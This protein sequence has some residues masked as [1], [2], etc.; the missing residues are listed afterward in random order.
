MAGRP[1]EGEK[2]RDTQRE[3][4]AGGVAQ[5][6]WGKSLLVM[7]GVWISFI[8]GQREKTT[9]VSEGRMERQMDR[10][11]GQVTPFFIH[12]NL[13]RSCSQLGL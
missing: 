4:E 13:P 9:L 7:Q 3:A 6:T 5:I 11:L 2:G 1:G 12:L 10:S 8:P